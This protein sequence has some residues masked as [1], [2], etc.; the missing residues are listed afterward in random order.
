MAPTPVSSAAISDPRSP[1]A[2]AFPILAIFACTLC[3]PALVTHFKGRNFAASVLMFS[4]IIPDVFNITNPLI[5]PTEIPQNWW[6]GAGLCDI[7]VKLEL[8]LSGARVGAVACIFRQLAIILDVDRT[9]LMPSLGQ[10]RRKWI[11]ELGI[12]VVVPIYLMIAHYTV[13]P[14]R[15]YIFSVEGCTPSFDNSWPSIVLVFIWPLFLATIAAVYGALAFY[16]LVIYRRQFATILSSSQSSMS[17]SRFIRLFALSAALIIICLPLI[18]FTFI[19]NTSFPRQPY[20]WSRVH[21]KNWS[22]SIVKVPG[23]ANGGFD[24]WTQ[25]GSGILVFPFFGLGQDAKAL[26]RSWSPKLRLDRVTNLGTKSSGQT[27]LV[28]K[29]GGSGFNAERQHSPHPQHSPTDISI[30]LYEDE[31]LEKVSTSPMN[32]YHNIYPWQDAPLAT[33]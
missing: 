27:Q 3:I 20:S 5:W 29:N 18:I 31:Q 30:T 8:A 2:I 32:V 23:Q 15:Y 25:I 26:Y 11:F 9:T 14:F 28:Y 22:Q 13:Q 10:R 16:R 7:E 6:S 1:L 12:C 4:I 24:H 19:Q 17:R 33:E 21:P